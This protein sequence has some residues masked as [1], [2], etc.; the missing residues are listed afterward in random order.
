MSLYHPYHIINYLKM[1]ID[2]VRVPIP[3]I[4][5]LVSLR[6]PQTKPVIQ[7]LLRRRC[8]CYARHGAGRGL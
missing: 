5:K 6:Y 4:P 7:G 1:S 8:K 3:S 2:P